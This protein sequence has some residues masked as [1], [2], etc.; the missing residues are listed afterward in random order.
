MDEKQIE[1][2]LQESVNSGHIRDN[3]DGTFSL[4]EEGRIHI[5]QL[6]W[7][8]GLTP[9]KAKAMDLPEFLEKMGF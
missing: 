7:R 1:E 9:D 5:E 8:R 4:T 3:G 2:S 6:M